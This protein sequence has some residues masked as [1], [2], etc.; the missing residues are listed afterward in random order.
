[1]FCKECGNEVVD[2]AV[3]CPKCGSSMDSSRSLQEGTGSN[4]FIFGLGYALAVLIPIVGIII[5]I[6]SCFKSSGHGIAIILLS[7]L[8][9]ISWACVILAC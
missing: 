8:S 6:Y 7:I 2:R 5:G 3:I 9:W 4:G 1:M